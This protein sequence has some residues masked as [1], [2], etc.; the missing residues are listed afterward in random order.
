MTSRNIYKNNL[1]K[2]TDTR[3]L[4]E[5]STVSQVTSTDSLY[6]SRLCIVQLDIWNLNYIF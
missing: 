3:T 5:L 6:T 2:Y 1:E 4:I